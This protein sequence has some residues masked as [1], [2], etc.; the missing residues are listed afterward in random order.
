[1]LLLEYDDVML[2][3]VAHNNEPQMLTGI[4][5]KENS[6]PI[7]L[8]ILEVLTGSI[9]LFIGNLT[10]VEL[11]GFQRFEVCVNLQYFNIFYHE[12]YFLALK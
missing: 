6:S 2:F 5:N 12:P 3:F 10:C 7:L 1:M 8:S 9:A 11:C 4:F